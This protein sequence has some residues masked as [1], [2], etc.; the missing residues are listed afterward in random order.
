M[1]SSAIYVRVPR[2]LLKE[3]DS[4]V[5]RHGLS[6]SEAVRDAMKL[7]IRYLVAPS[8]QEL[9]GRVRSKLSEEVLL[10]FRV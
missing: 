6:R 8:V 1:S 2:S 10:S 5:Q 7:Y 3:F 9:Y 4:V